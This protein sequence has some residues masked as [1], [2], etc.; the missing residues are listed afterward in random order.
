[1]SFSKNVIKTRALAVSSEVEYFNRTYHV[2]TF[3]QSIQPRHRLLLHYAKYS[4]ALIE[5][6]NATQQSSS[7]S[8]ENENCKEMRLKINFSPFK[9]SEKVS[10]STLRRIPQLRTITLYNG[11]LPRANVIARITRLSIDFSPIILLAQS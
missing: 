9:L 3:A 6:F 2:G 8:R 4:C 1:M 11:K 10:R 7:V 5:K